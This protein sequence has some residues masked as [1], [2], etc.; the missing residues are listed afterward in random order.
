MELH[1]A[2]YRAQQEQQAD[3]FEKTGQKPVC[4]L[5]AAAPVCPRVLCHS[6]DV[7]QHL[8]S[9]G[10]ADGFGGDPSALH[11]FQHADIQRRRKRF[12]EVDIRQACAGFPNLKR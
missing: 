8:C 4:M 2:I 3:A 1:S 10:A 7:G 9:L 12:D 11:Q 5:E 6:E